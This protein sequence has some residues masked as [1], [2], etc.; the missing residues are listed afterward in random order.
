MKKFNL[1]VL[2]LIVFVLSAICSFADSNNYVASPGGKSVS[3]SYPVHPGI[4]TAGE[5]A[6]FD[7]L[8]KKELVSLGTSTTLCPLDTTSTGTASIGY[9]TNVTPPCLIVITPYDT[10]TASIT[11][12][13]YETTVASGATA[14]NTAFVLPLTNGQYRK[15]FFGMPNVSF[16]ANQTGSA[17]V[18]VWV[19]SY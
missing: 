2:L 7:K 16:G 9:M 15:A 6:V 8:V 3:R 1:A 19:P 5:N 18:E 17:T 13:I 11:S 14:P 4:V 12:G 10:G